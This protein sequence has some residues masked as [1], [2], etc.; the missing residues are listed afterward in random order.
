EIVCKVKVGLDGQE[1]S[2]LANSTSLFKYINKL[3][4][5][6][7]VEPAEEDEEIPSE[8]YKTIDN[9]KFIH[10]YMVKGQI[11]RMIVL[12]NEENIS[13][14]RHSEIWYMD[15]TF[16]SCPF[17]FYQV[18]IIHASIYGKTYSLLYALLDRKT[19]NQYVKLFEYVRTLVEPKN[20]KR[21]V[22]DFEK[23]ALEAAEEVFKGVIV[24]GCYFHWTQMVL[25]NLKV[26]GCFKLYKSSG[27]FRDL[28]KMLLSLPFLPLESVGTDF[29]LLNAM[30]NMKFSD[31]GDLNSFLNYFS[32][33]F[34]LSNNK[35]GYSYDIWNV[36]RRIEIHVPI[37]NNSAEAFNKSL[38]DEFVNSH[39]S[40]TLFIQKL[41]V[42]D[43]TYTQEIE[44]KFSSLVSSSNKLTLSTTSMIKNEKI[45]EVLYDE[46]KYY[47]LQ[48]LKEISKIYNWF[49]K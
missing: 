19:K 37:T 22:M 46:K 28:F 42:R 21:I 17:D 10:Y 32:N 13:H 9:N 15:G 7:N 23:A 12:I 33:N 2:V 6:N 39:P 25:R 31:E 20:I 41:R 1:K 44:L 5:E 11:D 8:Y 48:L 16:K 3:R 36:Y 24:E 14:L 43:F 40:L 4:K 27:D 29:F 34:L 35:K 30:F 45:F 26:H 18:Y 49:L 47:E 38:G